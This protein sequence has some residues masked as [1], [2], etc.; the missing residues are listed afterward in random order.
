M[1]RRTP[2]TKTAAEVGRTLKAAATLPKRIDARIRPAAI[3]LGWLGVAALAALFVLARTP[4]ADWPAGLTRERLPVYGT[5]ALVAASL[6]GWASMQDGQAR[7]ERA[8]GR[9]LGSLCFLVLPLAAAGLGLA[10][11]HLELSPETRAAWRPAFVAAHWYG[12]CAVVACLA[13][14]LRSKAARTGRL[15]LHIL[16]LLPFASL[17]AALVFGFRL[18][19]VDEPLRATLRSLGGSAVALQL[20]LA[21]F[22]GGAG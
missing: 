18:P 4:D 9:T 12:P 14:F 22:I 13:A 15:V 7:L 20:V 21:W 16:L 2:V 6:L 11:S 17:L 10:E 8:L 3:L 5:L 1:A 19:W